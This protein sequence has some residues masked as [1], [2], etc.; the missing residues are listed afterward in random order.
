MDTIAG[1]YQHMLELT[2][3][4]PV[5]GGAIMLWLMTVITW[6]CRS[7]PLTL[8]NYTFRQSTTS[9][10]L[11]NTG[12]GGNELNYFSFLE[13]FLK[14]AKIRNIRTFSLERLWIRDKGYQ[15]VIGAGY[16]LQFFFYKGRLFWFQR[17]KLE[18]SATD[19]LKEEVTIHGLTRN[20][21]LINKMVDDFTFKPEKG[22]CYGYTW[23]NKQWDD[24]VVIRPRQIET[25]VIKAKTK[26][27]IINAIKKFRASEK[28]Y[29]ER[30]IPYKLVI[31]LFGPPG[32]GKTSLIRALATLFEADIYQLN[33]SDMTDT[34]LTKAINTIDV[35]SFLL[36]DDFAGHGALKKRKNAMVA[37]TD[38]EEKTDEKKDE[39][40][41]KP[42]AG[43]LDAI[44][45]VFERM[46]LSGFLNAIDGVIPLHNA[47]IFLASN[48]FDHLDGSVMRKGRIDESFLLDVLDHDTVCDYIEMV[49]PGY[50]FPSTLR[51][52]PILG[53]DLA[54]LYRRNSDDIQQFIISIPKVLAHDIGVSHH[55]PAPIAGTE[56][57]AAL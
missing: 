57:T 40:E 5:F 29:V 9:L 23:N 3:S 51:F 4:A 1:L 47:V 54:D 8:W 14:Q 6:A 26:N 34:S 56:T 41:P 48:D 44:A 28:W 16:G 18:S 38:E 21:E 37:K 39:E 35:G 46:T 50:Y 53:C 30:G 32:T 19:K 49:C 13:W 15:N 11:S 43:G 25:V 2:K 20:N 52:K 22:K 7:I 24:P 12:Y 45:E 10:S 17:K 27:D 55:H 42:V 36:I 33:L 31:H